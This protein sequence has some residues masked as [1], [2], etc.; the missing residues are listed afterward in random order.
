M[1][2]S[3][4]QRETLAL[5]KSTGTANAVELCV[6]FKT[7]NILYRSGCVEVERVDED[8][9]NVSVGIHFAIT[10]KGRQEAAA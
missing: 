9:R 1:K 7:L 10:D 8:A 4:T 2:L 5:L 6:P 3:P